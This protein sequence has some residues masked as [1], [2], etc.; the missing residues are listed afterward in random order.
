[1]AT[2][3]H[4]LCSSFTEI[5]RLKVGETMRCF[6][7]RKVN[8]VFHRHFASVWRRYQQFAGEGAT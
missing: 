6:D 2:P 8:A 1:M 3:I 4:V 7:E 5:G